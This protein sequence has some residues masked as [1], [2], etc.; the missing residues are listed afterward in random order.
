MRLLKSTLIAVLLIVFCLSNKLYT[1]S[2]I[3]DILKN[4][5]APGARATMG[6]FA[7]SYTKMLSSELFGFKRNSLQDRISSIVL[8]AAGYQFMS[9]NTKTGLEFK[10]FKFNKEWKGYWTGFLAGEGMDI[11]LNWAQ[12]YENSQY[13]VL[14]TGAISLVTIITIGEIKGSYR[15]ADD[16]PLNLKNLFTNRHSYWEHFAGS[17]GLYWAISNHTNSKE[18]TLLYTSIM[19]WL[20]ELKDG[21]LKW[22]DFGHIGGDG[23]SWRDG[24]AGSIAAAGSYMFDKWVIPL[25]QKKLSTYFR[26][27]L[28]ISFYTKATF[29]GIVIRKR[30]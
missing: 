21:Y 16:G 9:Y 22:E 3:S 30:L 23:F 18:N 7:N 19:I 14:T 12:K 25:I 13:I 29:N 15:K 27:N 26:N 2:N 5:S 11:F 10:P 8:A 4:E 20:W 24:M 6:F 1:K 28:M 17:G